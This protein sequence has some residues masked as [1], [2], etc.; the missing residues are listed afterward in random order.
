MMK[1]GVPIKLSVKRVLWDFFCVILSSEKET[2]PK[3][4]KGDETGR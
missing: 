1:K 2:L 3:V 4:K